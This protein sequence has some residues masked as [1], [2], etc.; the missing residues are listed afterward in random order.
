MKTVCFVCRHGVGSSNDERLAFERYLKR[1]GIKNVKA[2]NTGT[3]FRPAYHREAIEAADIIV[4]MFE[5]VEPAI[6]K[7]N[8]NALILNIGAL[9]AEARGRYSEIYSFLCSCQLESV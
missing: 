3:E 6:R 7:I 4:T 8:P 9:Y 2:T 1:M 5:D